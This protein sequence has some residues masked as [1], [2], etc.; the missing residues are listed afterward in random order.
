MLKLDFYLYICTPDQTWN[1][2]LM[3]VLAKYFICLLHFQTTALCYIY[4]RW[5]TMEC[6]Y[7]GMQPHSALFL[8]PVVVQWNANLPQP[9]SMFQ[10]WYGI[11]RNVPRSA[12][13]Y[14]TDVPDTIWHTKECEPYSALLYVPDTIW[15]TMEC[16]PYSALLGVPDSIW[17]T[18]EC[19][20]YSALLCVPDS[21]WH[22][23][24]C[25]LTQ[26]CSVAKPSAAC[27]H[28]RTAKG[29][30]SIPHPARK[31]PNSI[32]SLAGK[33]DWMSQTWLPIYSLVSTLGRSCW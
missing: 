8:V 3:S 19:E 2:S 33:L 11:Q 29:K 13:L 5:H 26:P 23:M 17:R 4:T 27:T 30:Q 20:P 24:E 9:Y 10:T 28:P 32:F 15:R 16:E 1:K 31:W 18:M 14:V 6:T 25:K 22:T 21:I 12:L 7:N